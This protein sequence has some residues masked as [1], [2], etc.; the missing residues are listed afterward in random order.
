MDLNAHL[1]FLDHFSLRFARFWSWYLSWLLLMLN[2]FSGET[3]AKWICWSLQNSKAGTS[4][5][6]CF[7][8]ICAWINRLTLYKLWTQNRQYDRSTRGECWGKTIQRDSCNWIE[9][10]L[11]S[12][13]WG[14]N[15]TS[16][17]TWRL[18]DMSCFDICT[19]YK[20]INEINSRSLQVLPY[21]SISFL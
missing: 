16:R 7:Q 11:Y 5:S 4:S 6:I 2:C 19:W 3:R 14:H 20:C 18:R 1:S 17:G 12:L 15:Q 10:M 21:I 13:E 9:S 8:A